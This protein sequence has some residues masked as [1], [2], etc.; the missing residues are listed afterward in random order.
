MK[1]FLEQ[2]QKFV[3]FK[4]PCVEEYRCIAFGGGAI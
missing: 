2:M 3:N 4:N 1:N